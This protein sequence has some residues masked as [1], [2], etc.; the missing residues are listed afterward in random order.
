MEFEPYFTEQDK[1]HEFNVWE[2]QQP[3]EPAVPEVDKA[4]EH[5]NDKANALLAAKEQG[6]QEG[7]RQAQAEVTELKTELQ[8]WIM[9][10]QR[11]VQLI[12]EQLTQEFLQTLIWLCQECIGVQLTH[13]PEQLR[14]LLQVLK[15]ELPSLKEEKQLAMHPDDVQ[16]IL[17]Y[18][19]NN[20]IP[21]LHQLL[22]PD[23]SLKR[24]D[25]YLSS[26][27]K[28]LDGRLQTRIATILAKYLG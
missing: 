25:F 17:T 3:E 13:D 2:Y 12:D 4:T 28:E 8:R 18:F 14:Q 23:A 22:V 16:W 10:F 6:Y 9:L 1:N 24:G 20:E 26:E 5:E 19:D 27:H 7:L 11:P 21:K 15:E